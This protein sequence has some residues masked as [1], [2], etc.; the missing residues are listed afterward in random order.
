[1]H[2]NES[3]PFD[4]EKL[5]LN[6]DELTDK[7]CGLMIEIDKKIRAC[8]SDPKFKNNAV[9][10]KEPFRP[11]YSGP[12]A[13]D[14][15]YTVNIAYERGNTTTTSYINVYYY[16]ALEMAIQKLPRTKQFHARR[17]FK[18]IDE[19]VN[20]NQ[21][22]YQIDETLISNDRNEVLKMLYKRLDNI[23]SERQ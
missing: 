16:P 3:I 1:M 21:G 23:A 17:R 22:L 12:E 4:M 9:K 2:N 7:V 8:N 20:L 14:D 10:D 19:S 18:D 5:K 11:V 6:E 13:I 15:G